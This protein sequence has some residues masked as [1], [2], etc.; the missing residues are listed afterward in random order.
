MLA[1]KKYH[2]ART[3]PTIGSPIPNQFQDPPKPH[4]K[5]HGKLT[6]KH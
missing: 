3:I 5:R 2:P 6:P 4:W 1:S